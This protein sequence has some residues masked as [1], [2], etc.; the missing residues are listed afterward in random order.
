MPEPIISTE[1][2]ASPPTRF[3]SPSHPDA[4]QPVV[5][6][7]RRPVHYS[8]PTQDWLDFLAGLLAKTA[9]AERASADRTESP[10]RP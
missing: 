8:Q 2:S 6:P 10:A 4:S 7:P 3:S 5:A 9:R 1:L